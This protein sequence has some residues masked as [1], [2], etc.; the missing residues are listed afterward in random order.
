VALHN[1]GNDHIPA[2][3]H[4]LIHGKLN[5]LAGVIEMTITTKESKGFALIKIKS[6]KA[7]KILKIFHLLTSSI[8]V[9]G[10]VCVAGL[11]WICF[12][13]LG[14]DAFGMIA[15]V[16]PRLYPTVI[17]PAAFL[18]VAQGL[19]YGLFTNWGFVKHKWIITKWLLTVLLFVSMRV[20]TTRMAFMF[21]NMGVG[22]FENRFADGRIFFFLIAVQIVILI[23]II[24]ISVLKPFKKKKAPAEKA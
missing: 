20:T 5:A 7:M 16:V 19:I 3:L 18:T 17:A 10:I 6:S 11:I 14:E 12:S 8:W 1:S 23:A 9:G 21:K 4:H 2:C 13:K 24:C 22:S 15:P